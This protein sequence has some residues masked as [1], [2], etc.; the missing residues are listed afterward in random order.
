MRILPVKSSRSTERQWTKELD[1]HFYIAEQHP[2]Q[3][4]KR[5]TETGCRIGFTNN[6]FTQADAEPQ[7]ESSR[8]DFLQMDASDFVR[9]DFTSPKVCS[10]PLCAFL[11]SVDVQ[12][13]RHGWKPDKMKNRCRALQ[14]ERIV[15]CCR[16]T[17]QSCRLET[18]ASGQESPES[19]SIVDVVMTTCRSSTFEQCTWPH[20]ENVILIFVG[21][22]AKKGFMRVS[23][24]TSRVLQLLGQK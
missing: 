23:P 10:R 13:R 12:G 9:T 19:N 15:F 8:E 4:K 14:S 20:Y 16:V 24:L 2:I 7:A 1:G 22:N 11:L 3:E 18:N 17:P 21:V 6:S 5:Q